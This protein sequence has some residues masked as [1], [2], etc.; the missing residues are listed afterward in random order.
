MNEIKFYDS[1]YE[2]LLFSTENDFCIKDFYWIGEASIQEDKELALKMCVQFLYKCFKCELL[3][4]S[5]NLD[6]DSYINDENIEEFVRI[7]SFENLEKIMCNYPLSDEIFTGN[8]FKLNN[9]ESR[10]YYADVYSTDLLNS[11]ANECE[12]I[13]YVDNINMQDIR[14]I[15]FNKK[16]NDIFNKIS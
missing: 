6:I 2:K 14:W 5:M 4:F 13:A 1:L 12:L 16:I 11:I 3:Y 9:L 10:I 7:L 8:D 15:K